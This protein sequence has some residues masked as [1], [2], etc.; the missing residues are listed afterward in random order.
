MYEI[1]GSLTSFLNS[2]EYKIVLVTK[3]RVE[4]SPVPLRLIVYVSLSVIA[5]SHV[6]QKIC[7]CLQPTGVVCDVF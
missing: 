5:M 4:R 7:C 1:F 2:L 6:Q 3:I